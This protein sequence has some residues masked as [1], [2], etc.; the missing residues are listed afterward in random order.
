MGIFSDTGDRLRLALLR[1]KDRLVYSE[2]LRRIIVL[3]RLLRSKFPRQE[4]FI[5]QAFEKAENPYLVEI[6]RLPPEKLESLVQKNEPL[7][8]GDGFARFRDLR[9]KQSCLTRSIVL[10]RPEANGEKGLLALYFEYNL[11]RLVEGVA[12]LATLNQEFDILL[13]TSWSPTNYAL[14]AYAL[15]KTTGTLFLQAA[16]NADG[17]KLE[18]FHPHLKCV[19]GLACDWV[20]PAVFQPKPHSDREYDFVMVANWAPFKRH[21]EFFNALSHMPKSLRI[22]LIGQKE[23]DYT[24]DHIRKLAKDLG[25]TQQIDFFESI[26]IE[27]VRRIQC[28]SKAAV[29][30]SRREGGCVAAVEAL[31]ANTPLGMREDAHVGSLAHVNAST[32]RRLSVKRPM[33][34][35]LMAL[36]ESAPK[37]KPRQWAIENI[38]CHQT[39]AKLNH[40]LKDRSTSEGQPWTQDLLP[41]AWSPY[42]TYLHEADRERMRPVYA[43]LHR[44][45][46]SVFSSDLMDTSHR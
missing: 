5:I 11:F 12:D 19:P 17:S 8:D 4:L 43:E 44:R 32:G 15:S 33:H 26:P 30:L 22:A 35:E 18:A 39:L 6:C 1:C 25:A 21:F 23:G 14:L 45:Y 37:L 29:I 10:K 2:R 24:Q 27:E 9:I 38:S 40:F 3:L 41:V 7:S 20:N 16:N 46:P 42:P 31:F 13:C 28:N 34:A 36:L